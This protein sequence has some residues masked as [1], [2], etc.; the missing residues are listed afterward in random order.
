[1]KKVRFEE[2]KP[3]MILA[4]TIYSVDGRILVREKT[5]M[6]STI[7]EKLIKLGLPAA[8]IENSESNEPPSQDLVSETT[9]MDLVN[10][11]SKLDVQIRSGAGGS[12]NLLSSKN[13]LYNLVDEIVSNQKNLLGLTDIR[14][15]SDYTYGHSVHVSIIAVKIGLEMGYNQ[16]K[17]SELAVGALF[18][19]IGMT[20]VPWD[21]LDKAS[22]L[23]Q[24][25]LKI[26][27]THPEAGYNMLRQNQGISTVSAHVAYQHH[28]RFNG[29]GYPRGMTGEAIH[30]FARIVA[31][32]DVYDSMT[33]EKIYRRAISSKEALNVIKD[34]RGVDFDPRIVEIFEKVVA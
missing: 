11:L 7:L 26:V 9:R 24:D 3:G 19:D 34:K 8:Y 5:E 1:M 30:E 16:L 10:N 31:I 33:T 13:S 2:L 21:I 17:L 12:L 14:L 18:H 23:T 15:H 20:K 22:N 32:A 6:T 27:R 29:A 4:K 25:E 28:E